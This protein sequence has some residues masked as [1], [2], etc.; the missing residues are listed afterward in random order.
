MRPTSHAIVL[1]ADHNEG[2]ARGLAVT[3]NS[4]LRSLDLNASPRLYILDAGVTEHTVRRA[5]RLV[6]R[7]RPDIDLEWIRVDM[8]ALA[9]LPAKRRFPTVVY[10]RL[11]IP[12]LL[13]TEIERVVFLD[14]DLLIER[15]LEELF[16][17]DL[18]GA[19][20][21]GAQ[22]LGHG[23]NPAPGERSYYNA[24][25]LVMDLRLWRQRGLAARI[26]RYVES[27]EDLPLQDQ[28][29]MNAVI[30]DW[31]RLDARWNVQLGILVP[32]GVRQPESEHAVHTLLRE[33]RRNGI[34][35][36]Y[37]NAKPWIPA[38]MAPESWR[39]VRASLKTRWGTPAEEARW[40]IGWL[41]GRARYHVGTARLRTRQ[42]L[43]RAQ[44]PVRPDE[45]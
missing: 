13:P 8:G 42:R 35:R 43:V 17:L 9:H 10:A 22:D 41:A 24:G 14:A 15:D 38:A 32:G 39:W 34:V 21:A 6:K 40:L 37:I 45:V 23:V 30:N 27:N 3:I 29:A 28:D 19:S 2:F 16:S 18:R 31:Y 25:V 7:I 1:S 20:I 36:H 26:I 12:E 44:R 33:G 11:L 4:A 5:H